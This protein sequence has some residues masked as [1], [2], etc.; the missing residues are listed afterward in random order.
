MPSDHDLHPL[1]AEPP[2]LL[3]NLR[4]LQ[5]NWRAHWKL[6]VIAAIV[7]AAVP[8]YELVKSEHERKT[9]VLNVEG[10]FRSSLMKE[11]T[12]E[13][14]NQNHIET[15]AKSIRKIIE[16]SL[17]DFENLDGIYFVFDSHAVNVSAGAGNVIV[18]AGKKLTERTGG[19]LSSDP[20]YAAEVDIKLFE[21]SMAEVEKG[22]KE[23]LVATKSII[24]KSVLINKGSN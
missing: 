1:Q 21:G 9:A 2:A 5:L 13:Q 3:K 4:W 15:N 18:F 17:K 16:S 23:L 20:P 22:Y 11:G 7:V 24:T 14:Q 12:T 10:E 8:I 19:I 6:L